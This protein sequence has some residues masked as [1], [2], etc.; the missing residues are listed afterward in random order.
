M[1]ERAIEKTACNE[2]CQKARGPDESLTLQEL[3]EELKKEE[4]A[5][6]SPLGR[7]TVLLVL[8]SSVCAYLLDYWGV[9]TA[10]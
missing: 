9:L 3:K 1:R 4:N 6:V 7:Y 10:R 2:E 8:R 5:T